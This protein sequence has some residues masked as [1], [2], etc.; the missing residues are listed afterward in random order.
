MDPITNGDRISPTW[1]K[2][3]AFVRD[4][5]VKAQIHLEGTLPPDQTNL[6]RGKLIALRSLERLDRDEP[7]VQ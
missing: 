2:V 5:I 3:M 6:V 1:R 4:E 7:L